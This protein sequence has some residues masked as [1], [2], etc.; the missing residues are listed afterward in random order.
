M[1]KVTSAWLQSIESLKEVPADQLQWLIDNSEQ[2]ELGE[3]AFLFKED[4][5]IRGTY[6]ILS[7]RLRIFWMQV[8]EMR[9][10]LQ[11]GPK[12]IT[13][14]LPFSRGVVA[15]ASCQVLDDAAIMTFPVA[16][17]R[18]LINGHFELTQA[19]VHIMT[20]RVR[21]VA[22]MQQQDEKMVALGKLSAGL[23]H[24]LNNPAAAIVRGS[25]TL[26]KH[27][28]LEPTAFKE[29]MAIRMEEKEVDLVTEKLFEILGRAEK[30][31]LTLMERTEREDELRDW[32]EDHNVDNSEEVAENFLDYGFTCDDLGAFTAHIPPSNLVTERMVQDIQE[33]S[34]RI[35]ELVTSVKNFTHM[36]QGKGKEY[37][38]IRTG[39]ANTLK[40]LNYKLKKGNIE[41]IEDYDEHLP[42]V[43]A[44]IGELNQVWT[45]LIDNAIDAMEVNGKGKLTIRTE[46]DK[47]FAKISI[48]DNG[49][50][51]PED[52]QS[53][54]FEPFFTTKEIGKGTGLGLDVVIR[55]A[56]QHRGSVKVDSHAGLTVFVVCFPIDG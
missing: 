4:E 52:I 26:L 21:E 1:E 51:I 2:Y 46:K 25:T 45:N 9:E 18:E 35:S 44:M 53:H 49:P 33:S 48:I 39:I 7:G 43:K 28:K 37:T 15:G 20:S 40:M 5:P 30:P 16:K 14:Y 12:F 55:I 36:D 24:E 34:Q 8:N 56:K 31:K 13:G 10:L 11:I 6:I 19:L 27:L 3:G 54:I 38:D 47:E 32:L 50:G 22:S 29:V 23:A 17:A 41:I 42:K